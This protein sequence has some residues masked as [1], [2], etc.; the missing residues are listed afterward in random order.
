MAAF[1]LTGA[2]AGWVLWPAP[3]SFAIDADRMYD[4]LSPYR[5]DAKVYLLEAASGVRN[6][7]RKNEDVIE[8]RDLIFKL[9][10][11]ALGTETVLWALS[12]K[13]SEARKRSVKRLLQ[14]LSKR[15]PGR[16]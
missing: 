16:S 14:R 12:R 2:F 6:V 7:L 13:R 4:E 11:G 9:A 8:R 15:S 1:L 3:V 5:E 10:L